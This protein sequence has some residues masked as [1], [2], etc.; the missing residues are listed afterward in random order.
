MENTDKEIL[1][2]LNQIRVDIQFIKNTLDDGELTEWAE[3]E[4][5]E[6]RRETKKIS[7]EE[8]KKELRL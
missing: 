5:N 3:N 2:Q 8:L 4:L 1:K 7:H 6:A